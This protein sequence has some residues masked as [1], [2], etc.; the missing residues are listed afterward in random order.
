MIHKLQNKTGDTKISDLSNDFRM[1]ITYHKMG[2]TQT[3][4]VTL[5]YPLWHSVEIILHSRLLSS[6]NSID[7]IWYQPR[8]IK[9]YPFGREFNGLVQERCNSIAKALEL[10]L[11]CTYSSKC[12]NID[13]GTVRSHYN[14]VQYNI[15]FHSAQQGVVTSG[16]WGCCSMY[17][18]HSRPTQLESVSHWL[19]QK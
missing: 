17:Y 6:L 18:L 5:A 4:V 2:W 8:D 14:T 13:Y 12:C 7:M 9:D 11:S 10:L 19:D 16:P 1:V 3:I 15:I